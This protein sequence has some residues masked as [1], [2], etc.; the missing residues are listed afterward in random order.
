MGISRDGQVEASETCVCDGQSVRALQQLDQGK[1]PNKIRA[2]RYHMRVQCVFS[3]RVCWHTSRAQK[4]YTSDALNKQTVYDFL[5]CGSCLFELQ[6]LHLAACSVG[7]R[8]E[9]ILC[10]TASQTSSTTCPLLDPPQH[11][12]S[13]YVCHCSDG[14]ARTH[15]LDQHPAVVRYN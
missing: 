8:S 7:A 2:R 12:H 9:N 1:T 10:D 13:A 5:M 14:G 3:P 15:P 6:R 11:G 4:H